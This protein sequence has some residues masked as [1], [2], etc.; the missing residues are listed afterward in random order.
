VV[1]T[2]ESHPPGR[3]EGREGKVTVPENSSHEQPSRK[4]EEAVK[5]RGSTALAVPIARVL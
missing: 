3:G 1:E 2:A 4:E 5:S